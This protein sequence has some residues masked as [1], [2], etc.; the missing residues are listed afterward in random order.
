MKTI[1]IVVGKDEIIT[2]VH[3]INV[4]QGLEH[5][6]INS[7]LNVAEISSKKRN[8]CIRYIDK[9]VE[10]LML[11]PKNDWEDIGVAELLALKE[12]FLKSGNS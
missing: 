11:L 9:T 10:E 5:I 6:A 1:A 12:E 7:A 2:S 4:E 8:V 3:L